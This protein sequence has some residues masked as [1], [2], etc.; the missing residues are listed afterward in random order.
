MVLTER[1][2]LALMLA[3]VGG[4]ALIAALL[5]GSR[6]PNAGPELAAPGANHAA[7]SAADSANGPVA[8]GNGVFAGGSLKHDQSKTLRDMPAKTGRDGAGRQHE[9]HGR[10]A[11]ESSE[12]RVKSRAD[13]QAQ[14]QGHC[15]EPGL[16]W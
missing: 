3:I 8:M 1:S 2:R 4:L 12:C 5:L 7:I 11:G 15:P 16:G 14:T 10:R 13:P 6:P 9:A